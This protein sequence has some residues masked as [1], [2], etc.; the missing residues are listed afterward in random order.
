[1]ISQ[2]FK[3]TYDHD[4]DDSLEDIEKKN[5]ELHFIC[6]CSDREEHLLLQTK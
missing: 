6:N 4:F 5:T 2:Y 1:M 3:G